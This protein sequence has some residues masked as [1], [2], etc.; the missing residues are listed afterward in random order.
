MRDGIEQQA[1]K[2][3]QTSSSYLFNP[4]INDCVNVTIPQVDRSREMRMQNIVGIIVDIKENHGHKL[5]NVATRYGCIRPLLSRNQ[6]E[7]C[8]QRNVIDMETVYRE[9]TVSTREIAD[10]TAKG[11]NEGPSSSFCRCAKDLCKSQ[12]CMCRRKG[13][14]CTGRCQHGYIPKCNN[15]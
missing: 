7:M 10:K 12:R 4:E 15:M 13:L 11:Y 8:R 6:F 14:L 9:R 1:I 3:I 5:Y 2:M